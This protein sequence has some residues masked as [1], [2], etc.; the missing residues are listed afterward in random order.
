MSH[1]S[2]S[3]S[4]L[5]LRCVLSAEEAVLSSAVYPDVETVRKGQDN[6]VTA[7]GES[8]GESGHPQQVCPRPRVNG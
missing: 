1:V 3:V 6:P 5:T 4:P 2:Q 7:A 8:N